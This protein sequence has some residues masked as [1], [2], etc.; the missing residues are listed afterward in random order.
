MLGKK[1]KS[2]MKYLVTG[3]SGYIGG[4]L[5][6]KLSEIG[7]ETIAFVRPTSNIE[8]LKSLNNVE[9][10]FGDLTDYSSVK[11]TVEGIQV[12]Y[13]IGGLV[14]DWGD[15]QKFYQANFL[16]TENILKASLGASVKKFIYTSTIGVLNLSGR[17]TIGE[18][19]PY[20]H[21]IGS[22]RR[23]KLEAEKLVRSYSG[24]IPTVIIRPAVVYGP[25][26]PQCTF[27]SLKYARR[28]LLFLVSGGKGYFPHLYI[29]N[30]V[31]ALILASQNEAAVGEIFNLTDG[32][33]TSTKDFFS[34]LN[35]IVGKGKIHLSLPYPIAWLGALFMDAFSRISHKPPLLSWTALEFLTL[36][37]QFDI[38]KSKEK[39]GFDPFIPLRE[40]MDRINFWWRQL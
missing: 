19:D 10:R 8:R 16:G 24:I 40:G 33:N 21:G 20:G 34:H 26:D 35:Q 25:E 12:V 15:Y 3:A 2:K 32:V 13:H 17:R 7:M 38:S 9:I 27:R 22:Y 4:H 37:C 6:E 36:K 1:Q 29:D 23:S 18:D 14:N 31:D 28:R 5:V 30:L 11:R 39:L